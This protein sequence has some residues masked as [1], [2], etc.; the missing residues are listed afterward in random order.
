MRGMDL[1]WHA[2]PQIS[3]HSFCGDRPSLNRMK[4]R[5][6]V[7]HWSSALEQGSYASKLNIASV[8]IL[9]GRVTLC[10]TIQRV[11]FSL[12]SPAD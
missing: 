10:A 4:E 11:S 2:L 3:E 1:G 5:M 12:P 6:R 9:F 8:S 7:W